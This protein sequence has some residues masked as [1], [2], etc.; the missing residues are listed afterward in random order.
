MALTRGG[1]NFVICITFINRKVN[2]NFLQLV[3]DE[4]QMT[5]T[6]DTGQPLNILLS[7]ELFSQ[8]CPSIKYLTEQNNKRKRS[9]VN[10]DSATIKA[11]PLKYLKSDKSATPRVD[12]NHFLV[13]PESEH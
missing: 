11:S 2:I 8:H 10:E 12:S 5:D 7:L 9:P 1:K 3:A 4:I 13:I 6:L